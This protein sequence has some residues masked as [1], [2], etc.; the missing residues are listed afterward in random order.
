[1]HEEKILTVIEWRDE[2]H[3]AISDME[4]AAMKAGWGIRILRD[5][6]F[7]RDIT[8]KTIGRIVSDYVFYRGIEGKVVF[9]DIIKYVINHSNRS[10]MNTC[11]VGSDSSSSDK[12]FQHAVFSCN[13]PDNVLPAKGIEGIESA[14]SAAKEIGYPV[15]IKPRWE[16]CGRGIK[17]LRNDMELGEYFKVAPNKD[18]MMEKYIPIDCD[19]RIFIVGGKA[20]GAMR[21]VGDNEHP[22]N[23][24]SWSAGRVKTN[25]DN[26]DIKV[27]ISELAE[28]AAKALNAEYGGV[29]IIYDKVT[30]KYYVLE[31]NLSAGWHNGFGDITGANVMDKVFEWCESEWQKRHQQELGNLRKV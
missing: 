9:R 7:P 16:S 29:D 31:C 26:E 23:F 19:W 3:P 12:L 18:V 27:I 30:D 11:V 22:E 20:I 2:S 17:L 5:R 21:K 25:E 4:M 14:L 10:T 8:E 6:D 28:K 15:V 24:E 13:I 1:M